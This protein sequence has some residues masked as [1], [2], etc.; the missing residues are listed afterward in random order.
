M[1]LFLALSHIINGLTYTAASP[2]PMHWRYCSLELSNLLLLSI[3]MAVNNQVKDKYLKRVKNGGTSL[4]L[5]HWYDGDPAVWSLSHSC[6]EGM[7][8]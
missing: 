8:S 6:S 5:S 3:A 2:L 1:K 4:A 7:L